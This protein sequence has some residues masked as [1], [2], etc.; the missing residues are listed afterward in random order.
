[1]PITLS[2]DTGLKYGLKSD[3]NDAPQKS[4]FSLRPK[5]VMSGKKEKKVDS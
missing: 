2:I 1:M 3:Q 4:V 5:Y